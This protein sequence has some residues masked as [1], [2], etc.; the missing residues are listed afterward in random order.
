MTVCPTCCVTFA[1]AR[2]QR[3]CSC[4][5]RRVSRNVLK[6]SQANSEATFGRPLFAP[7]VLPG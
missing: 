3:Y 1:P 5:A 7:P 6:P 4:R 2:G